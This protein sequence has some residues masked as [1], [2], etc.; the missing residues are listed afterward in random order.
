M[1]DQS[2]FLV[3]GILLT[4]AFSRLATKETFGNYQFILSVL[5]IVSIIS[6]PGINMSV[7]KYTSQGKDG[8][9]KKGFKTRFLYSL[10]AIPVM[11]SLGAYFFYY[12]TRIIGI[13]LMS[14]SVVFP[15]LHGLNTWEPFL[16]GK[17]RFKQIFIYKSS[18]SFINLGT[19]VLIL[20]LDSD[21][22]IVIILAYMIVN[23][24]FNITYS[25]LV[26][27]L[28]KNNE[29]VPGWRKEG[30]KLTLRSVI[31]LL[32]NNVDKI[33]I[34]LL[35]GPEQLAIYSIAVVTYSKLLFFLKEIINVI[36]PKLFEKTKHE[37]YRL[38]KRSM[39]FA[40]ISVFLF[41]G[42]VVLIIPKL[43]IWFFSDKYIESIVYAQLYMA[44]IP[45]SFVNNIIQVFLIGKGWVNLVIRN[46]V[47]AISLN[48]LLYFLLIP[49]MGIYGA[50]IS[51]FIYFASLLFL[52]YL[53]MRRDLKNINN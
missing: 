48:L 36:M 4:I 44:I 2:V 51:S 33:I 13:A 12:D 26:K 18:Y 34:G 50:I 9:Y 40:F 16:V 21:N 52:N 38:D 47:I 6:M 15:F 24:V 11:L 49:L 46:Q 14:I 25:I 43:Y 3:T 29:E 28:I 17:K 27:K 35:M 19:L 39:S 5:S 20:F 37:N 22:L 31:S 41:V 32:Y 45:L 53:N 10:I 30:Y 1:L 7:I 8:V 23:A 42:I